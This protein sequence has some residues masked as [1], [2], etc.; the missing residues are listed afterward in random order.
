MPD[1]LLNR[2]RSEVQDHYGAAPL[3][4]THTLSMEYLFD[5]H[6]TLAKTGLLIANRI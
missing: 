3:D 5:D 2:R 6:D 1:R 4:Y